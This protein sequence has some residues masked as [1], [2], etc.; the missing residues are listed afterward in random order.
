MNIHEK[1]VRIRKD[2]NLNQEEFAERLNVSRQ[3]VSNWENGKCFPDIETLIIISNKFNISLD[4]LLKNDISLVKTIDKKAKRSRL[5]LFIIMVLVLISI[6]I[7]V[8][9]YNYHKKHKTTVIN[10]I[11]EIEDSKSMVSIDKNKVV[12][13]DNKVLSKN[14]RVDIYLDDHDIDYQVSVPIINDAVI[15]DT[16]KYYIISVSDNEYKDF[17]VSEA[18][19]YDYL[20]IKK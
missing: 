5:Y 11:Y 18:K 20:F 1:L 12:V 17:K 9:G 13:K 2:S 7:I 10:K 3:T 6:L 16:N 19:G 14:D 4:D 15:Y 8:V